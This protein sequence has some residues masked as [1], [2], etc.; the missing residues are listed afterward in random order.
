SKI[1]A[2]PALPGWDVNPMY[3]TPA[4]TAIPW[5][6]N[7]EPNVP[8]TARSFPDADNSRFLG[9]N[10]INNPV[11]TYT[12]TSLQTWI[13][14]VYDIGIQP[15][16]HTQCYLIAIGNGVSQQGIPNNLILLC[17]T[18]HYAYPLCINGQPAALAN[19][20]HDYSKLMSWASKNIDFFLVSQYLNG[21]LTSKFEITS[22]EMLKYLTVTTANYIC[23]SNRNWVH[24]L[25]CLLDLADSRSICAN[26]D[27]ATKCHFVMRGG[28]WTNKWS[29]GGGINQHGDIP[30]NG[31][32]Y[33]TKRWL[34]KWVILL[35]SREPKYW[36]S[37]IKFLLDNPEQDANLTT[38]LKFMVKK[39]DSLFPAEPAD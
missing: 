15:Q 8:A 4:A 38:L 17:Q 7:V 39:L 32:G 23:E 21:N 35:S 10:L 37:A 27:D 11:R 25:I 19:Y 34:L 36:K 29:W 24:L 28:S 26:Y 5:I 31:D 22:T 16:S 30:N 3:E 14:T 33:Q 1:N 13:R 20:Q 12:I 6:Q 2:N 18:T 9:S